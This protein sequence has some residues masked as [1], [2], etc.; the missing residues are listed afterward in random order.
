MALRIWMCPWEQNLQE[1]NHIPYERIPSVSKVLQAFM[2]ECGVFL[3]TAD[4]GMAG[5][6]GFKAGKELGK[7]R[8]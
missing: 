2:G 7:R 5:K 6:Y 1:T 8:V 3:Q 4:C